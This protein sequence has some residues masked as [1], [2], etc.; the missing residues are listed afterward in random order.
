MKIQLGRLEIDSPL[1][2]A[3]IA[4]F[5]DSPYRAIARAHGAG[6]VMTELVSC[7]A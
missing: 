3:P 7:E 2:L 5:T 6:F 4:G 1:V